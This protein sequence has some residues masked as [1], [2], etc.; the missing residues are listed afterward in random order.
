MNG[1]VNESEGVN[2]CMRE[3]LIYKDATHEHGDNTAPRQPLLTLSLLE[4]SERG[5]LGGEAGAGL[6]PALRAGLH[7]GRKA[8]KARGAGRHVGVHAGQRVLQ[9]GQKLLGTIVVVAN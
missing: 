4:L 9:Q 6:L 8:V 5:G 3:M 2:G 7:L 1:K